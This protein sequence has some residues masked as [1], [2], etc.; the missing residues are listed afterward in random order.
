MCGSRYPS[1]SNYLRDNQNVTDM[2][3]PIYKQD[4]IVEKNIHEVIDFMDKATFRP[5]S[6]VIT[7]HS[8]VKGFEFRGSVGSDGFCVI[9]NSDF[10]SSLAPMAKASITAINDN[11]CEVHLEIGPNML[12]VIVMSLF[13]I[14]I[15]AIGATA[16]YEI[17]AHGMIGDIV[18]IMIVFILFASVFFLFL[19]FGFY[20]RY[21]KLK[22]RMLKT[23][24]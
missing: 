10:Q 9:R 5:T 11:S 16:I 17:I 6:A 3:V 14:G 21:K 12:I 23:L 13:A 2:I 1:F 22:S 24:S 19:R 15:L 18:L 8:F 4:I 7:R 20:S